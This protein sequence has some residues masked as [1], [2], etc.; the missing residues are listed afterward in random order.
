MR[1]ARP[2]SRAA[3]R[4]RLAWSASNAPRSRKT[5]AATAVAR[6]IGKDVGDEP[7]EIR[8]GVVELRRHGMRTEEGRHATCRGDRLERRKLRCAIEPVAGLRLERRRPVRPHLVAVSLDGGPE[9]VRPRVARRAHGRADAATR[10][11]EL[12]IGR[13]ACA[14]RELLD[15]VARE[16]RVRVAVDEARNRASPS[17]VDLVDLAVQR[18]EVAH[19]PDRDDAPVVSEHEGVLDHRHLAE[20]GAAQ[21]STAPCRRCELREIADE[22]AAHASAS[23]GRSRPPARAASSASS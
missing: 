15:A 11:M 23:I 13:A 8:V 10:R 17:A 12:L 4:Y 7:V 14:Q 22:K 9:G 2:Q 18:S 19:R 1:S 21:R 16:A 20:R 6:R 3:T 5:S